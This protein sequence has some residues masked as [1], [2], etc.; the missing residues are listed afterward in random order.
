MR[1]LLLTLRRKAVRR[2]LFVKGGTQEGILGR[3]AE[4]AKK[5][6]P[7]KRSQIHHQ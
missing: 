3:N 5:R 4:I 1:Q 2:I 6:S 7:L